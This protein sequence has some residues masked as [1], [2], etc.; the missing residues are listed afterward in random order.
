MRPEK[1]KI[2]TLNQGERFYYE[3]DPT[4]IHT[5]DRIVGPQGKDLDLGA[6]TRSYIDPP[7]EGYHHSDCQRFASS[8][9][10]VIKSI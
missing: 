1:V 4:E 3:C 9:D 2:G 6:R 7:T 8:N 5:M 10:L